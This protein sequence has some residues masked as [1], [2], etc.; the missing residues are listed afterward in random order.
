MDSIISCCQHCN[1]RN[2]VPAHYNGKAIKCSHC[3]K[4]FI[5]TPASSEDI[6]SD[7]FVEDW[8]PKKPHG[9]KTVSSENRTPQGGEKEETEGSSFEKL[10][11]L[12]SIVSAFALVV[13]SVWLVKIERILS[14]VPR[15]KDVYLEKMGFELPE[16]IPSSKRNVPYVL[17][18]GV[19]G[20]VEVEGEV[21]V[22]NRTFEAIPV[23]VVAP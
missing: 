15:Y 21:G 2:A 14:S 7:L 19:E 17:V 16:H 10:K 12:C 3:L 9:I 1:T 4:E 13:I 11:L 20:K 22:T 23:K 5:A 6:E 8:P 18:Q